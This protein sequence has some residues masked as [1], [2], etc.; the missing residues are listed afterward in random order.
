MHPAQTS[1]EK[2]CIINQALPEA[3]D[4]FLPSQ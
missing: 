4:I 2:G 1:I 3:K